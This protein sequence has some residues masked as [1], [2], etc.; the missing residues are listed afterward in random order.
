MSMK[1]VA[2]DDEP[3]ALRIIEEFCKR[4][5]DIDIICFTDPEKGLECILASCPQ[6]VFLDIEMND[7]SG[8]NIAAKLPKEVGVIFTTAYLH[9]AIDGFNL[10]AVDYLHKPFSYDRFSEA[11][12]R[13]TRRIQYTSYIVGNKQIVVK[14]D[15][16]NV[17]IQVSEISYI[18]AME[19][20][21]KVYLLEGKMI[22]AHNT[23][24]NIT[25][26]MPGSELVRIHKSY[27]VPRKQIKSYTKQNVT[28]QNQTILPVGRQYVRLLL[29]DT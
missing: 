12:E 28:L 21:C 19:N 20:Y 17:P 9:Y 18:E 6:I 22:L 13:A 24:K 2:I 3:I 25:E 5:G 27:I 4:R 26:Q 11:I 14:Q 1:C 7:T 15:Y 8:L 23:L 10:D 29:Q 16:S